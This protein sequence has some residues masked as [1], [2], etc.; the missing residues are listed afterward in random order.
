MNRRS[1]FKQSAVA[2]MGS[3]FVLP[4]SARVAMAQSGA[5]PDASLVSSGNS[6]HASLV[7]NAYAN[8]L[9]SQ[10]YSNLIAL[11]GSLKANLLS[12]GSASVFDSS[13]AQVSSSQLNAG[14]LN[15]A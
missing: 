9:S 5:A 7:G 10:D 1:F 13:L 15:K 6:S 4:I 2:T 8:A 11:Y 3:A 14:L 12:S